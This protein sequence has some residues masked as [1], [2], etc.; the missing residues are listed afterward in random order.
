MPD[1]CTGQ[2]AASDD[3]NLVLSE[4]A[5]ELLDV[6]LPTLRALAKEDGFPVEKRD[7]NGGP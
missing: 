1:T 3:A 2:A 4:L 6:S 7:S 5:A